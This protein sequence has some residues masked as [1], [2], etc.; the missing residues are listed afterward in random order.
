MVGG[1]LCKS[2][3]PSIIIIIICSTINVCALLTCM[4]TTKYLCGT[5]D[6][7]ACLPAVCTQDA[8]AAASAPNASA[9]AYQTQVGFGEECG[10]SIVDDV[11]WV[12]RITA[13]GAPAETCGSSLS[14]DVCSQTSLTALVLGG[15][16]GGHAGCR[17]G[18]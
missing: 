1:M 3:K 9:C 2:D 10:R 7:P 15:W 16:V 11:C 14:K 6:S 13:N 5:T 17:M 8:W 18:G 4:C 12:L